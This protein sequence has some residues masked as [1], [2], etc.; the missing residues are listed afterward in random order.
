MFRVPPA[1]AP[2][3]SRV[4][5]CT[6]INESEI[7]HGG[8]YILHCFEDNRVVSHAEIIVSAPHFNFVLDIGSV[9]NWEFVR[10]PIDVIEVTIRLVLV[11]LRKLCCEK[12]FVAEGTFVGILRADDWYGRGSLMEG[13]TA[14]SRSGFLG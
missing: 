14:C 10:K 7:G 3:L 2:Y 4:R 9:S 11:L 12:L 8:F 13:T 1:P 5:L 6:R